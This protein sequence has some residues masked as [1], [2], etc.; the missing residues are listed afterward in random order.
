M[1]LDGS[2]SDLTFVAWLLRICV[3]PHSK[4]WT[5]VVPLHA[6]RLY[7]SSDIGPFQASAL[8]IRKVW[9]DIEQGIRLQFANLQLS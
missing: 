5:S 8:S 1:S 4:L 6:R 9:L 7:Q 3:K 2:S